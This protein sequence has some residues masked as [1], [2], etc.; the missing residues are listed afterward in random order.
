MAKM[1]KV[2]LGMIGGGEGAFIGAVHRNAFGLDGQY[3][4][5][6]GAFSRDSS[7]NENTADSLGVEPSRTYA[8]WEDML[9]KEAAL[10]E[11]QRMQV[12]SIVTPNHLHVP[13]SVA[14]IKAGFH[15]FCEKPAGV[16]LGEVKDLQDLP[17]QHLFQ[18]INEGE[19]TNVTSSEINQYIQ[20]IMGEEFIAKHFRKSEQA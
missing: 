16:G 14:A 18:Y 13:I 15:V 9:E 2:R 6:C 3:D 5:V 17:G 10:P 19:C 8:S 7:N 20:Q 11:Q 1:Q 12:V 4:L